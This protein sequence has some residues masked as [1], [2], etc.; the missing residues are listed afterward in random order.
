MWSSVV[1]ISHIMAVMTT[2][3]LISAQHLINA[4]IPD[5]PLD[6]VKDFDDESRA[7]FSNNLLTSR[8]T[9]NQNDFNFYWNIPSFMCAQHNQTFTDMTS[10]YNIVQNKDDKW[11]GDKIVILYDPGKFPALLE[12]QGQLYRRNGGVPQEG[13]LQEHIDILAEH[14]NKLIPDT[15][16]SGIGVI[17]FESWRPIFRQNSGVLQPYKDLSMKLVRR[18]HKLWKKERVEQEATKLFE[19]AGRR[20]VEETIKVAQ[21]LR[22]KAKWGYYGFPYCFNMN[23]G[24]NM[25]EDCPANVKDENDQIKWLWD[26]VDVVLPSVYL[27]NK[28]TA[29]QRVQFVRGRMREG[30]R[31]ARMS[32][33]TQKPP[34]LAYLRYVYTDTLK[35][36][37]NDDL[38]S[39]IKVSKEQKS[40]GMIFW[41]SS[42]D[43]KTRDQCSD[44]RKYVDHNLGPIVLSANNK[45]PK[46]LTPNLA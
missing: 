11:R 10:S 20:F 17:D 25:N 18:D 31:V 34:V 24:A 23:G 9:N 36:I 44:F 45:S 35:F 1:N 16:F 2:A 38:K 26:I 39:A 14:I 5:S 3:H 41:G 6:A 28:I 21:I 29:A 42:Y 33:Q 8:N 37:S 30:Y 40:N 46:V 15:G 27:N 12:H 32:K 7:I 22:P 19:S 43:V 13:N 4:N